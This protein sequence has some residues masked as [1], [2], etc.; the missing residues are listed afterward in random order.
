M[1]SLAS[2]ENGLK[3]TLLMSEGIMCKIFLKPKSRQ[4]K[5]TSLL[6]R[7]NLIGK[8]SSLVNSW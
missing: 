2:I 5:Q 4:Q 1:Y 3:K 8:V 6:E 7:G